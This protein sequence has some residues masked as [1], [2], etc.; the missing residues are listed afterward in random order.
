MGWS[1]AL[2]T[3]E[4]AAA[5]GRCAICEHPA[6][7]GGASE[8]TPS[9]DARVAKKP[10]TA[11]QAMLAGVGS[12]REAEARRL[13]RKVQQMRELGIDLPPAEMLPL[14]ARHCYSV[15]VAANAYFERLAMADAGGG[16]VAPDA[17]T[18]RR[19]DSLVAR[20]ERG[21]PGFRLLGSADMAATVTR[22]GA[23][24]RAGQELVLQ[25]ENVGKKRLRPGGGGRGVSPAASATSSPSASPPA[26]VTA[27]G[28]VRVLDASQAQIGRLER[29]F[30]GMLH[31]LMKERLV[32]LGGMCR[33]APL[34][35]QMFAAF[36]VAV[37]VYVSERAFAIFDEEHPQ[38]YL[39][40]AL[41]SLLELL[42]PETD[43]AASDAASS[44]ADTEGTASTADLDAL[45]SECA[46]ANDMLTT[47]GGGDEQQ[48]NIDPSEQLAPLLLDFELREHQKQALRWML[49][50]EQLD[51]SRVGAGGEAAS[52]ADAIDPVRRAAISEAIASLEGLTHLLWTRRCGRSGASGATTAG[53]TT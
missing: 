37:F 52:D 16:G 21:R 3:F 30:E 43:S 23:K 41:Y 48:Q 15:P 44:P 9:P 42:K 17:E 38:F 1:C 46:G 24:L 36:E 4:N 8:K 39:A 7:G 14:L 47:G 11:V 31:P 25:A 10:R 29:E 45:F 12:S 26:A 51:Q 28:F 18:A 49:W 20:F 2:C 22:S 35:T 19:I 5:A 53:P 40:D 50:R 32:V 13:Q 33:S 6:A 34:S 27:N